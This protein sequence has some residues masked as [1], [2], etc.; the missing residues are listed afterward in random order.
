MA[1]ADAPAAA[2]PGAAAGAGS[3]ATGTVPV[4]VEAV[5]LLDVGGDR[6][7]KW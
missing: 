4:F 3:G 1:A 7:S 2:G 6:G 5:R